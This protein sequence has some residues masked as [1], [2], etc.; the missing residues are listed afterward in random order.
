MAA[1]LP[2]IQCPKIQ[3]HILTKT[4]KNWIKSEKNLYFNLCHHSCDRRGFSYSWIFGYRSHNIIL[5]CAKTH[6]GTFEMLRIA[7]NY[8][9]TFNLVKWNKKLFEVNAKQNEKI[10]LWNSN[11]QDTKS[12][13]NPFRAHRRKCI[14]AY[15]LYLCVKL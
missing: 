4:K 13:W 11:K 9:D 2:H 3:T 10:Q 14:H 5:K 6:I 7:Q 1:N 15:K 8:T 12:A